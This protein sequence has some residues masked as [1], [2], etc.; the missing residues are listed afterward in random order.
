MSNVIPFPGSKRPPK[1]GLPPQST[2]AAFWYVVRLGDTE[3][4]K[5]WLHQHREDA[6]ALFKLLTER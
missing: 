6:P 1:T 4:L 3:R 5:T 2:V